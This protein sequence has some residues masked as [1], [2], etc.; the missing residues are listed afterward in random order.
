MAT[1]A[2]PRA[3]FATAIDTLAQH[4]AT[5]TTGLGTLVQPC[6]AAYGNKRTF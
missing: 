6:A 5:I 2:Q 4:C 3:T 1:P